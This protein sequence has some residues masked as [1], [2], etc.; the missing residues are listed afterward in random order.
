MKKK[1]NDLQDRSLLFFKSLC[2]E[3]MKKAL[4]VLADN[5]RSGHLK[6]QTEIAD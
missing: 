2:L 3:A 6:Q 5:P 4:Q 1:S